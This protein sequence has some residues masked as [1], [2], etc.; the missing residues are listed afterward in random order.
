MCWEG[1]VFGVR[2]ARWQGGHFLE[3]S[4]ALTIPQLHPWPR[5]LC[6]PPPTVCIH[7]SV[8]LAI[9][10]HPARALAVGLNN[11]L[12]APGQRVSPG[13]LVSS[14]EWAESPDY[15]T[16]PCLVVPCLS[17]PFFLFCISWLPHW[18]LAAVIPGQ[19]PLTGCGPRSGAACARPAWPR[20]PQPGL[21][22]RW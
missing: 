17:H 18:V 11:Q 21:S 22:R 16:T 14:G 9:S 5:S 12:L 10:P 15:G 20:T 8:H 19:L 6:L 7:S 13:M 1:T 4:A 3:D 2:S